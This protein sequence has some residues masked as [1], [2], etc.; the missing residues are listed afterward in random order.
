MKF[1]EVIFWSFLVGATGMLTAHHYDFDK[2]AL[3]Q[4]LN[5]F[6]YVLMFGCGVGATF[7]GVIRILK[8]VSDD[9]PLGWGENGL[10]FT[11]FAS[12]VPVMFVT[13]WTLWQLIFWFSSFRS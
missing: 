5:T 10:L 11:T 1:K 7:V 8:W 12:A 2:L 4:V 9:P 13:G 3:A 6:P